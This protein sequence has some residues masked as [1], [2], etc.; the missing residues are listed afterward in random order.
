MCWVCDP[1]APKPPNLNDPKHF[2]QATRTTRFHPPTPDDLLAE[3]TRLATVS[4]PV[5]RQRCESTKPDPEGSGKRIRTVRAGTNP[6]KPTNSVP[7]KR[8]GLMLSQLT[9]RTRTHHR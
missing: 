7:P 1:L 9:Q 5:F 2:T 3:T 4:E 8:H 6:A